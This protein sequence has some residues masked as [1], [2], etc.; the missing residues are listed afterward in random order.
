VNN[1]QGRQLVGLEC[2]SLFYKY[3]YPEIIVLTL[4]FIVALTA[5]LIAVPV[6]PNEMI[7]SGQVTE[8]NL[9][10][11]EHLDTGSGELI[12]KLVI[13]VEKVEVVRGANFLK[14]KE[15][16]PAT[17]FYKEKLHEEFAGKK[18]KANVQYNGDE[19]GGLFWI[20]QIEIIN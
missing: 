20:K 2:Q 1:S 4:V 10:A 13:V 6:I 3:L 7:I 15:N 11:P 19:R 9:N 8:C 17:F 12:Y 5:P 18:V 14:N 16:K